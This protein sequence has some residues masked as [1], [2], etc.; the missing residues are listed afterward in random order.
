MPKLYLKHYWYHFFRTRCSSSKYGI[1]VLLSNILTF[2]LLLNSIERNE[3]KAKRTKVNTKFRRETNP[4]K[5]Y[6]NY[7]SRTF[8]NI[9]ARSQHQV[10]FFQCQGIGPGRTWCSAAT[11]YRTYIALYYSILIPA[12]GTIWQAIID[13]WHDIAAVPIRGNYSQKGNS[14]FQ[15]SGVSELGLQLHVKCR[16][17]A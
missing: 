6:I 12:D 11:V 9:T 7:K 8:H 16:N 5:S 4:S 14:G 10:P 3:R 17:V 2:K 1:S 13:D 15:P